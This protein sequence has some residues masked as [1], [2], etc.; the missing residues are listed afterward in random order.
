MA[1]AL[2]MPVSFGLALFAANDIERQMLQISKAEAMIASATQL[3][4]IAVETAL[5]HEARAQDQW[6][7][8][9]ASMQSE[10]GHMPYD[11]PLEQAQLIQLS[12]NLNLAQTIYPRL[13]STVSLQRQDRLKPAEKNL[14]T[15]M[16]A[17]TITALAVITQELMDT[18]YELISS[19][20]NQAKNAMRLMQWS[21][22]LIILAMGVLAGFYWS[23]IGNGIL[24]PLRKLELGTQRIAAG[25]Y[26][27]RLNLLR[28]DEIGSLSKAFDS[29]TARVQQTQDELQDEMKNTQRSTLALQESMQYTMAILDNAVDGIITID[30]GGIIRSANHSAV[31]IFAYGP[32][33]LLGENIKTL[34]PEQYHNRYDDYIEQHR[35]PGVG[36]IIGNS[37]E[38]EGRRKDGQRFPMDLALSKTLHQG[39][40][41]FVGLVR[42]ISE[43]HLNEKIKTEFVSTVSHELRTPLTSISGALGLVVAGALGE[44]PAKMHTMLDIAHKN[45]L[46]LG[47]LI[48][49]LLDMEKMLAGKIAFDNQVQALMPVIE[50]ALES[51]LSFA[52]RLNVSYIISERADDVLVYVDSSRL[53]QVIANFLSNAAKYSPSEGQV[54]ISVRHHDKLVRVSVT[55]HGTG[56]P[57]QFHSRIFQKFAQADSSDTRAK[58]GTGLGL[59]ISKEFIERMK[60]NIGFCSEPGQGACFYFDLPLY[61]DDATAADTP[62]QA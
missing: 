13:I 39:L 26:S 17:R 7:R 37:R 29:M 27:H 11:S 31:S 62:D 41:L 5:F 4:L 59:A 23:L 61:L 19:N 21:I 53:Q 54:E 45:S 32:E 25:D 12:K 50:Q 56:I 46:R 20:R 55:D 1:A 15:E 18:G 42:D 48:D 3:R 22:G 24:R 34:I 35:N 6:F 57:L 47:H 2:V 33:E 51:T 58:G 36:K 38:L 16:E 40:A 30:E 43:R 10:I 60:G 9:V 49:D 52:E 8:K 44:M 14:N 28:T